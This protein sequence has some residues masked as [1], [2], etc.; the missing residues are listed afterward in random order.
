MVG[1]TFWLESGTRV[2]MALYRP[3]AAAAFGVSDKR[4]LGLLVPHLRNALLLAN[5]LTQAEEL[6]GVGFAA[7]EAL[8]SSIA[9]LDRERR[10]LFAN[11]AM[12]R[13][14]AAGDVHFGPDG[15]AVGPKG[16]RRLF[17]ADPA[18]QKRFDILVAQT[19]KGGAGAAIRLLAGEGSLTLLVMPLSCQPPPQPAWGEGISP[20]NTLIILRNHAYRAALD[21]EVLRTLFGL[22]DTEVAVARSL[23]GGRTAE[24]VAAKHGVSLATIRTH[25]RHILEKSGAQSLR[26]L[27]GILAAP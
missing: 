27:E 20:G 13:S 5:R 10:V 16:H 23:I 1:A 12:E 4:R 26:E 18:D 7:L 11:A 14:V 24:V 2:V 17:L 3:R 25:V 19:A 21:G 6:A 22:S 8:S 9:I 15:S